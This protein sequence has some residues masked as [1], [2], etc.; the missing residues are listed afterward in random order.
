MVDFRVRNRAKGALTVAGTAPA[1]GLCGE[2][3]TADA[4]ADQF[5]G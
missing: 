5:A 3:Q 1:E 2:L 4:A